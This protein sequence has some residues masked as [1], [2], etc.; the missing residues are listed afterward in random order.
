MP[1]YTCW[2]RRI[3]IS[4][5]SKERIAESITDA[6]HELA[7]TPHHLI[8]VLFAEVEPDSHF[9]G[10]VA[11]PDNQVWIRADNPATE[12]FRDALLQRITAEV[13]LILAVPVT[14]VWVSITVEEGRR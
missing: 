1:T 14:R 9:I 8:Q 7:G 11:A 5:E 12:E 3:G 10:G 2:S 13:A 6:H 4:R